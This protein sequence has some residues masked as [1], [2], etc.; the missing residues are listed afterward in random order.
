MDFFAQQRRVRSSGRW[1]VALFVL[2]VLSIVV[3]VDLVCAVALRVGPRPGPLL[4]VSALVLAVIG[5][6]SAYRV[7]SLRGGGSAVARGMDATPVPADTS[8]PAW[9]RLRNVI[10]EVAIASGVPV[11][12][13]WVMENEAGINAFA[14]GY[15][16]ADAAVCVTQGC[17][18]K[19]DRDELQG[20]IAHEFSHVLNGDM[21]LNIRLIGLLFGILALGIIGRFLMYS[22]SGRSRRDSGNIALVGIALFAIGYLGLFFGKL[23]QAAVARSRESLA[24][25]SA[26]QFTRQ[27]TG[28]A[29]ALKKIAALVDGSQ[30]QSSGRDEVRHM[31]FGDADASSLFATHP[32]IL[33]RIR[34]LEPQ[35]DP[36][37]LD[38]IVRE[39]AQAGGNAE[40]IRPT[41]PDH[42]FQRAVH[43]FAKADG[44]V[45][46]TEPLF[47]K[48]AGTAAT[49]AA[50]PNPAATLAIAAAGVAAQ[51]GTPGSDD[52]HAASA[53]HAR[54]PDALA[55]AA[56][57]PRG[58][59]A[60][61]F[62]LAL[63]DQADLQQRQLQAIA[64]AF[65]AS[66]ADAARGLQA[67]MG[68]LHPMLRL[69]LA[70]LAFP[71]LKRRP[72]AELETFT[73]TLDALIHADQQVDLDEYCLA[74]LVQAQVIAAL[75]PSA[76]FKAGSLRLI[77]SQDALRDLCALVAHFGND[78]M[79]ASRRA[80]LLAMQ[81][82]LP[83]STPLFAIPDD[84]Q[85]ALDAALEKLSRL[86]PEGKEL[87]V[88]ALTRAIAEDGKVNLAES[89]LL[90]VVC[91]VLGCPLP[92]V[93]ADAGA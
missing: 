84:W 17:L 65:D 5:L 1:L 14:A 85:G 86:N 10:E 70:Q 19:L 68:E 24:D 83:G 45:D 90:R 6:C 63:S 37:E 61:V 46:V 2:A 81:E 66:L 12:E 30:L 27:T 16:P 76:N 92:P 15:T 23:I 35:F 39:W 57:D 34:A 4:A 52:Y 20:V 82:A 60:V 25:A 40:S 33:A 22:G 13:I 88:R 29:G 9:K 42:P 56:R 51:V 55:S 44:D 62:A 72:R 18:D 89:E 58:A 79:D 31:L 73:R 54:M 11:P 50:L 67:R 3:A 28:I 41:H 53:L 69:P 64:Q 75:D 80:F 48:P 74:R 43:D 91:A 32:P 47:P 59:P 7:A 49:G 21:R 93:L 87:T 78:D 36:S 38:R 8:N 71:A 26:V 77:D